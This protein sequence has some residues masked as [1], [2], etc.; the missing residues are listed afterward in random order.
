VPIERFALDDVAEAWKR[1]A[2]GPGAKV[3]VEL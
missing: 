1:Q 3:V 2:S